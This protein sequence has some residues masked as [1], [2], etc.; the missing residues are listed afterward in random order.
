MYCLDILHFLLYFKSVALFIP[1]Y[2]LVYLL[3][4]VFIFKSSC[5]KGAAHVSSV[6]A[7]FCRLAGDHWTKRDIRHDSDAEDDDDVKK[8]VNQS[9]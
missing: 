6:H 8:V 2:C 3:S 4:L 9:C 7:C 5:A 1:F